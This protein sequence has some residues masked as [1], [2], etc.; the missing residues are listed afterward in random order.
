MRDTQWH[1][2]GAVLPDWSCL[3]TG[4]NH[5]AVRHGV[6]HRVRER[7]P[8]RE[9]DDPAEERPD[10]GDLADQGW[11]TYMVGKW[12][13]CPEAGVTVASSR[14]N[15]PTGRGFERFTDS[16]APRRTNGSRPGAREPPRRPAGDARSGLPPERGPHRQALE[17]IKDA[18]NLALDKPFFLY[19]APARAMYRTTPP[20]SGSTAS[21]AV[22]HG[23]EAI[24]TRARPQKEMGVVP[25]E[26]ELL[27][28]NRWHV[29]DAHR[30]ER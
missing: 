23:H 12:H 18:K 16:W 30:A 5:T 1:R 8:K 21:R 25:P 3:P 9:R 11:D 22:R 17:F 26:T 6:H 27:L 14:R 7:V 15:W 4:W 28:L 2:D 24:R 20:R 19:Y 10:R 29:R 13:L